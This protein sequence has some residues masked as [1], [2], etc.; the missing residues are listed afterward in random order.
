M[1]R[2][3]IIA[4]LFLLLLFTRLFLI[5]N[6]KNIVIYIT[7][8]NTI[9]LIIVIISI[10][11]KTY[12]SIKK[13]VNKKQIPSDLKKNQIK[14]AKYKKNLFY[15][16]NIGVLVGILF[17]SEKYNDALS[18][19]T[20]GVSLLDHEICSVLKIIVKRWCRI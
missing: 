20:I 18:I 8:I 15:I 6:D 11:E 10:L 7:L 17:S 12:I 4:S 14:D 13:E 19:F 2:T 1:K 5:E 16:I 9:S 3:L